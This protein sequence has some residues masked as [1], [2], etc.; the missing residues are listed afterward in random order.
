MIKV[1]LSG[2][3]F[4]GKNEVCNMFRRIS[5]PVFDADVV[6]RF[7]IHHDINVNNQIRK[8][9]AELYGTSSNYISPSYVN[10]KEEIEII[11]DIAE[12]ELFRAYDNFSE[13][14]K[15]SIY[16]IFKSSV[17]FEKNWNK[18]M[19][20]NIS[21]FSPKIT[22]ME[23]FKHLANKKVQDVLFMLKNE[24]DDFDKNEMANFVVHS[25]IGRDI[26]NQVDE[27]D[28]FIIDSYIKQ[29]TPSR[30]S[31][32]NRIILTHF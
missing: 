18:M 21:V 27:I 14:H 12:T 26:R 3:R 15:S 9:L 13:K 23:R 31:N 24:I 20:Y 25:Y 16:T 1:G 22:R 5:I 6:L 7:I 30:L 28:K 10:T 17:L 4:S 2:N 19:N 32:D 11:L 29:E 8:S